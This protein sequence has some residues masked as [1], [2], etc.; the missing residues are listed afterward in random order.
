M[1]ER[2]ENMSA[3]EWLYDTYITQKDPHNNLVGRWYR[4]YTMTEVNQWM[5]RDTAGED[6]VEM[7]RMQG[8]VGQLI[9]RI[10]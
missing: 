3:L 10:E 1:S 9:K 5:K 4:N 8:K 2:E 7:Y 6:I